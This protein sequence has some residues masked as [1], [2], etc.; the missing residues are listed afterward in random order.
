[1]IYFTDRMLADLNWDGA[2]EIAS[3][4]FTIQLFQTSN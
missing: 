1:M 2:I 3:N 4:R